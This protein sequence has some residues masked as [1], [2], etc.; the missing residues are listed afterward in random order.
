ML[1]ENDLGEL[2]LALQ[3]TTPLA[4]V[5]LAEARDIFA[6]LAELGYVLTKPIASNG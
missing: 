4:R 1:T 2:I 5:N 6:R 3:N